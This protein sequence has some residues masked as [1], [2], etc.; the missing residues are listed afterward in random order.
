MVNHWSR[1]DIESNSL[2]A[3]V[4]ASLFCSSWA[5]RSFCRNDTEDRRNLITYSCFK[6]QI[7]KF[8]D[9]LDSRGTLTFCLL[10]YKII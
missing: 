8:G 9:A 5:S 10:L 4:K 7:V 2:T 6:E 1:R 3:S